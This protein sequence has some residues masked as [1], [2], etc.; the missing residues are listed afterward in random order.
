[1]DEPSL[2]DSDFPPFASRNERIK[3]ICPDISPQS[4]QIR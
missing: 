2:R 1:M 4:S 3:E